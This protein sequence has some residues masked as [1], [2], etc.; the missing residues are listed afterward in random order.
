MPRRT[1]AGRAAYQRVYR[2]RQAAAK[3]AKGQATARAV[4]A[5]LPKWPKD[6]AG[7]LAKWSR[8]VLKV[9]PGH[10]L[11][12]KPM[13]LPQFAVDWLRDSL[14]PGVR[15]S[16]LFVG[17]K[18]AKS[19]IL[20]A[21]LL[22]RLAGPL[23]TAGY[24]AGIA[25]VDKLKANELKAQMEGIA[26]ASQLDGL[27]FLRSPA[28]GRVE[29]PTGTVDILSADKSAG[30][31]SGFDDALID[32]LGLLSERDRALVNGLRT[33][34]SAK[35][36]RFLAISIMGDAP[37]PRE[38]IKRQGDR[39]TVVH[40]YQ[41]PEDCMLDDRAAWHAANP[42][43]SCGIKSMSY[44]AD[45]ARRVLATPSD[46]AHFRAFDLNQ[47]QS[48]AREMICSLA[49]W[50]SCVV[51]ADD[52]PERDGKV[53]VGFDLGGSTSMTALVALWPGTG[54]LEAWGAFPAVPDLA[55]RAE[56]DNTPYLDMLERGEL[57]IYGGRVTPVAVFLK[58]CAARLA[59][60]R[61]MLA[62]ADRYRRAEG[63]EAL[64]SAGLRWPIVWR[65]TGAHAHADGSHDVRAFQKRVLTK[66]LRTAE[67][68][69]LASAV[70]ESAVRRDPAGNPAL[71]KH[72]ERG[73][74]DALSAAVIATGLAATMDAKQKRPRW[75]VVS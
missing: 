42:G 16:G 9:P 6:P 50:K 38:M 30:H 61:I 7:V 33:S 32:E 29:S 11:A 4:T 40:L 57:A 74:I 52:L 39:A 63:L 56:S 25:S 37:F 75:R 5:S 2:A 24:R 72:R 53:I 41:A 62:G 45:E 46:Q 14:A 34:T 13:V 69:L 10:P 23:R 47:P 19:T 22:A 59:G 54:R 65:G 66:G 60:Q 18:N 48:P 68:L 28:P 58:N 31:A 17:R 3:A 43:L 67:S 1:K 35:D 21:Y 26:K 27:R 12:G 55:I 8:A 64:E 49:D 71:D 36:G 15:E 73:R 44:M 20:A 51:P 70:R